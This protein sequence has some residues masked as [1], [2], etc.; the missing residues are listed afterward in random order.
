M[1]QE[2]QQEAGAKINELMNL[3]SKHMQVDEKFKL[4]IRGE[5]LPFQTQG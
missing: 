3:E 4:Q 2:I 1:L 5:A